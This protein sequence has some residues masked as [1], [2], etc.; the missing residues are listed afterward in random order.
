[1]NF[2][3]IYDGMRYR[4]FQTIILMIDGVLSLTE[5]IR[6]VRIMMKESL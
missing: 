3:N 4:L 1:M 6:M 2:V 5:T